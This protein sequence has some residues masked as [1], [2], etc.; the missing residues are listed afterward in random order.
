MEQEKR[1]LSTK[2]RLFEDKLLRSRNIYKKETIRTEIIRMRVRLQK[3]QY[4][5]NRG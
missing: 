1:H 3:M 2:I 5:C 4:E